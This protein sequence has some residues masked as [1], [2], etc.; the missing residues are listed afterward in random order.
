MHWKRAGWQRHGCGYKID[1]TELFL[2][3]AL[4]TRK[5]GK[6]P[7]M[8]DYGADGKYT[9]KPFVTHYGGWPRVPAG[10]LSYAREMNLEDES[11]G[12]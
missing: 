11:A 6:M 9:T 3:W 4:V 5:L 2:D 1:M 8:L 12:M 10:L 7:S